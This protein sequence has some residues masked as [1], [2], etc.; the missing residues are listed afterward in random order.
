MDRAWLE[1]R[2]GLWQTLRRHSPGEPGA[3]E[4]VFRAALE[5]LETHIGWSR[6]RV[7]A[8]LGLAGLGLPE[9]YPLDWNE[10]D[11]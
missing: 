9:L 10:P 11:A 4:A 6:E 5:Q 7:L 3:E 2:N 1:R 8:G